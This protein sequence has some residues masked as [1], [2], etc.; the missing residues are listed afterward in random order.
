MIAALGMLTLLFPSGSLPPAPE[1]LSQ[2]DEQ[3]FI[4]KTWQKHGSLSAREEYLF[5]G[6]LVR[7]TTLQGD[8]YEDGIE[9]DQYGDLFKAGTGLVGEIGGMIPYRQHWRVGGFLAVG[10]DTYEGDSI[11]GPGGSRIE[12]DDMNILTVLLGFRATFRFVEILFV[13]GHIA[14]G[15]AYLQEVD[16]TTAGVKGELFAASVVPA[17]E[18]GL[19]LGLEVSCLQAEIGLGYRVQGGPSRGDQ[20]GPQVDPDPMGC[21]FFELG[22]ALRF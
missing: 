4:H 19:R 15:A 10:W 2:T 13:E 6:L 18:A 21:L 12:A 22:G 17:G 3:D 16:V 8:W 14:A 20:A 5:L 9:D 11:N 1:P 7:E